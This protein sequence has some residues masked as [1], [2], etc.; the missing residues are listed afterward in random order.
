M[1]EDLKE[2]MKKDFEM[3]SIGWLHFFLGIEVKQGDN[4]IA[5]P[6]KSMQKIYW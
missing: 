6:K 2:S 4:E 5:I 1:I 3:T